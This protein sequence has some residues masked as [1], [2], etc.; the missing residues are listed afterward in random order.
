MGVFNIFSKPASAEVMLENVIH[1]ND[2]KVKRDFD[3]LTDGY[4]SNSHVRTVID[5]IVNL[6]LSVDFKGDADANF[7]RPILIDYLLQG[8]AFLHVNK[9]NRFDRPYRLDPSKVV[10]RDSYVY[11]NSNRVYEYRERIGFE[12][13]ELDPKEFFH[14]KRYSPKSEWRGLSPLDSLIYTI[15]RSNES[16][17]AGYSI[18]VNGAPAGVITVNGKG[19]TDNTV[20]KLKS[21]FDSVFNGGENKNKIAITNIP[22]I[23]FIRIGLSNTDL[24]LIESD[25][26]DLKEIMRVYGVPLAL[27][28]DD[29]STYNNLEKAQQEMWSMVL[30]PLLK[31]ESQFYIDAGVKIEYDEDETMAMYDDMSSKKKVMMDEVSKGIITIE[32]YRAMH[33]PDLKNDDNL[34]ENID[35][36]LQS[37]ELEPSI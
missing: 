34:N 8:E 5:K 4:V 23:N 2:V 36:Q 9:K 10:D 35:E 22:D 17:K 25:K 15:L 21:Y 19:F 6:A 27:L 26:A 1:G 31:L 11:N 7:R 14:L 29:N 16:K 30:F 24:N 33:Y 18:M 13:V 3:I 12:A 32:E 37:Q 20:K 28:L